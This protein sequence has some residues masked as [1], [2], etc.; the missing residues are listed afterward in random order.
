M[1]RLSVLTLTFALSAAL[2]A[3]SAESVLSQYRGVTLGDSVQAVLEQLKLVATDV[4]VV[5]ERPTV[6]QEVTWRPRRFISGTTVVPDPLAEMVLTFYENRLARISVVYDR[7]RT[8]GL[9]DADL[10]EAMSPVYGQSILIATPT[11]GTLGHSY[12]R[13]TIGHWEDGDTRLLLW[14]EQYPTRVGLTITSIASDQSLQ[15]AIEAGVTLRA[16]EAP[17]REV[18]R[19]SAEAAAVVAKDEKARRENKAGF[20]P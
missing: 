5:H 9:T 1:L 3:T 7:E 12:E 17:A 14:R 19:R 2:P 20:K 13:L 18:A 10:H 11:P 4:R 8:Q 16:A 15:E 6:V